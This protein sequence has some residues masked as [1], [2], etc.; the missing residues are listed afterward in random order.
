MPFEFVGTEIPDVIIIKPK[1]FSDTRGFFLESYK[2]SDFENAGIAY[3][4]IQDNH[5]FS[6]KGVLRGL[7]FQ[8]PPYEQGKLVRCIKGAIVDVAVDLRKGSPTF[9]KWVQCELSQENTMMLWIPPGFAHAFLV[10]S[11]EADVVYKVS[12]AEYAPQADG[13]IRWDDPDIGIDWQ[14]E[15]YGIAKPLLSPKDAILPYLKD[16]ID[17]L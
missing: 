2:K 16:V 17:R 6:I 4:F 13:G 11:D 1:V 8:Y 9:K 7:H 5:S 12:H 14:F 15:K 3:D 10:V